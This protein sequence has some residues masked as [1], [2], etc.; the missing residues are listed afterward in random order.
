MF[1]GF[2]KKKG[3]LGYILGRDIPYLLKK[4]TFLLIVGPSFFLLS[5]RFTVCEY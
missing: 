1:E 3:Q 4:N 2:I 5:R